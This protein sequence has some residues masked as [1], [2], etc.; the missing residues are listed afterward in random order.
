ME[1][2]S[3]VECF[4]SFTNNFRTFFFLNISLF[5]F[6][7]FRQNVFISAAFIIWNFRVK[8]CVLSGQVFLSF[9][10]RTPGCRSRKNTCLLEQ[11]DERCEVYLELIV[12]L[13]VCVFK[14]F[15]ILK[16]QCFQRTFA[17]SKRAKINELSWGLKKQISAARGASKWVKLNDVREKNI[18]PS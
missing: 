10:E 13:Y 7:A 11:A 4:K 12:Y 17:L 3:V 1:V 16:Y 18:K 8:T 2:I 14:Y 15:Y 5:V 9:S 6:S